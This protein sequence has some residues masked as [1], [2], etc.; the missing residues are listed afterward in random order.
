M[1]SVNIGFLGVPFVPR[2]WVYRNMVTH[3]RLLQEVIDSFDLTNGLVSTVKIDA[4]QASVN[5]TFKH[6]SPYAI[7]SSVAIPNCAKAIMVCARNQTLV[8]EAIIACALE[9]YR[10]GQNQYPDSLEE[11]APRFVAKLPMD[12]TKGQPFRYRRTEDGRFSL[13]CRGWNETD[14]IREVSKDDWS[15][16]YSFD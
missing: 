7:L 3:A 6:F 4:A 1:I 9:R 10:L 12:V 14:G 5:A 2:G 16:K 15:W 13:F 11:L 8:G